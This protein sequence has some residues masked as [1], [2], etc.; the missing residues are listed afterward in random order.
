MSFVEQIYEIVKDELNEK[1]VAL[2]ADVEAKL[3]VHAKLLD[4]IK[5]VRYILLTA[6][7][8]GVIEQYELTEIDGEIVRVRKFEV[9]DQ[10]DGE[11]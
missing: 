7:R 2:Y 8:N 4:E 1:G 9:E 6:K 5:G 10:Y 3:Y 11:W